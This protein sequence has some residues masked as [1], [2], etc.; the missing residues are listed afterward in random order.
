ML[1]N[2]ISF[3]SDRHL[4]MK[5]FFVID[6]V[7]FTR[8]GTLHKTPPH[9]Y[10]EFRFRSYAP[11]ALKKFREIFEIDETEY[12]VSLCS[13]P[14]IELSNPGASGSIFYITQVIIDKITVLLNNIN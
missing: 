7:T 9:A 6:S 4:L 2:L 12:L 10:S 11:F 14:M 1:M 3:Q 13:E 8:D 5:D